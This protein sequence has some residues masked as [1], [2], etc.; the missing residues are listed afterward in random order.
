MTGG[1]RPLRA[2]A[3]VP[4]AWQDLLGGLGQDTL[5]DSHGSIPLPE[6]EGLTQ[7]VAAQVGDERAW[8]A[9]LASERESITVT[10]ARFGIGRERLRQLQMRAARR[11]QASA[12]FRAWASSLYAQAHS[13]VVLDLPA[14]AEG[15]WPLLIRLARSGGRSDLHTCA[16]APGLWAL[17]RLES[18]HDLRHRTLPPGR[19]YLEAEAAAQMRLPRGVLRAVWPGMQVTRTWNGR[20]VQRQ[21]GWPTADWL[22]AVARVLAEAGHAVWEERA[23]FAA[24]RSLPGAPDVQDSTMSLALRRGPEFGRTPLPGVWRYQAL[25]ADPAAGS[26]NDQASYLQSE[27][28][29]A[30]AGNVAIGYSTNMGSTGMTGKVCKMLA[31][32]RTFFPAFSE[33]VSCD[34]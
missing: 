8:A 2:P 19:Y 29:V 11:V 5:P 24:V 27:P 17:V 4:G 30:M 22:R 31:D 1:R 25:A 14:Q 13:P 9:L 16:L 21:A 12:A 18:G 32:D 20:Y 28:E 15:T 3:R 34:D 6:L 23:L 33:G 10:A 7:E 26:C